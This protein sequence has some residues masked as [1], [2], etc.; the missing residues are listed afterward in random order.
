MPPNH[1][2]P[3]A[4]LLLA[5][6]QSTRMG[7]PKLLLPWGRTTILGQI[8]HTRTQL[9]ARQIAIVIAPN[10]API[11]AELDRLQF[12]REHRITNPDPSRGMFSSIRCAAQWPHWDKTITHHAI[13]LGDQPHISLATL[14]DVAAHAARHPDQITQ[15]AR[16][17]H[18]RHPVILPAAA[19][20]D[21]ATTPFAP[22]LKQ[23]LQTHATQ[24]TLL[25]HSDPALDLDLDTP[26][27]Y[28]SALKN[29]PPQL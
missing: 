17:G 28:Q 1:P 9:P 2:L 10:D 16:H 29:F 5:A 7:R 6:G 24:L 4:T 20:R 25:E 15:P 3:L 12:P 13:V 23:Y 11:H 18:G 26:A 22:D 27:D 14:R 21:L 19:F 8:L